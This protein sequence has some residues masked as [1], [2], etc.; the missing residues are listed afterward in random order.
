MGGYLRICTVIMQSIS[1]IFVASLVLYAS[2]SDSVVPEDALFALDDDLSEARSTLT[3]LQQAGKSWKECEQLVKDDKAEVEAN[4]KNAQKIIN[5][6]EV[7]HKCTAL[8]KK[9]DDEKTEAKRT[10]DEVAKKKTEETAA[11]DA[12]VDFGSRTF[13]SLTKG[14]CGVFF[15]HK[16][17]ISAKANAAKAA[18]ARKEA[19]G[20]AVQAKKVMEKAVAQA[21]TDTQKCLCD[22]KF[23]HNKALKEGKA[24]DAAN[25]KLWVRA[26]KLECVIKGQTSCKIPPVPSITAPALNPE[27][28]GAVCGATLTKKVD[29]NPPADP[30]KKYQEEKAANKKIAAALTAQVG[31]APNS[32][33]INSSGQKTLDEVA[34]VLNQYPWMAVNVQGHSD[35][36]KG[37]HC[38][39]LVNGRAESTKKFLASKGCKNKMTVVAGTCAKVRAITIGAQDTISAGAK[40]PAGCKA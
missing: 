36:K 34:K 6:L 15:T 19:E 31:F 3:S 30:C 37:T 32:V 23:A 28:N 14:D 26:H 21:K 13:S 9:A 20:A 40:L 5:S 24:N 16:N 18:Q 4:V 10:E 22:T 29:P 39:K 11:K 2:A 33:V 27:V 7:G 12:M 35:A 8:S 25:E 38:T 17:Y 1:I